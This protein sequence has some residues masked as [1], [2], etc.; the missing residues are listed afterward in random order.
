[1]NLTSCCVAC[2]ETVFQYKQK[3]TSVFIYKLEEDYY[4][5]RFNQTP[6]IYIK[7]KKKSL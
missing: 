3:A 2:I 6:Y 5:H 7:K 1:M 4:K